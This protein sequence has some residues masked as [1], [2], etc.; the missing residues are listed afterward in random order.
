MS[1][2]VFLRGEDGVSLWC[3][4]AYEELSGV[5]VWRL[6]ELEELL[7][8][9]P[10]G[11]GVASMLFGGLAQWGRKT[12]LHKLTSLVYQSSSILAHGWKSLCMKNVFPEHQA[13]WWSLEALELVP[14]VPQGLRKAGQKDQQGYWWTTERWRL[15]A[16]F[17]AILSG[18]ILGTAKNTWLWPPRWKPE[19]GFYLPL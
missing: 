15:H 13:T 12:E 19:V 4:C 11:K 2:R 8:G 10:Q 14:G 16:G 17:V 7:L 3:G 1:A 6:S 18:R 9:L 5:C